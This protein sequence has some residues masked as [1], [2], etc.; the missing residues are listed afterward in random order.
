[1]LDY[2]AYLAAIRRN[3]FEQDPAFSQVIDGTL[4]T[5]WA[6][7][8]RPR[9]QTTGEVAATRWADLAVIANENPPTLRTHNPWGE[10]IDSVEVHPAYDQL[11]REAYEAGVVWPRF[12]AATGGKSSPWGVVFALGYLLGQA[13]QG[14]FCPVCLTAGTAWLLER[15]AE[16]ELKDRYLPRVAAR[17]YDQLFEGAMFLTERAGGSDVG[18]ATVEARQEDGIWKLYGDKWFCSNAGRAQAMMVLARPQGATSGTRGLAL[19]MVP[20]VLED[21]GRNALR[22]NRLKDKL[23]TKS[24]PSG[25]LVFEGATAYAVGPL[26]RGFAA[27]TAMLNLS[28][29]YNT[30]ASV[31]NMRRTINT[32]IAYTHAR[33]AFGR[34][35]D[36]AP[37]VQSKLIEL[38]V[39]AEASLRL[40]FEAI[41]VLDRVEA[42]ESQSREELALRV[43]TPLL[44]YHTAREA[45]DTASACTE[46]LG[47]NGYIEEWQI[48]RFLRDAQVLPIWEGTTNIL[49]L[50]VL[51][52]FAKEGTGPALLAWYGERLSGP[53]PA[54]LAT[55]R[56]MLARE[57]ADL[58]THLL[59][60]S[61]LDDATRQV[62]AKDWCDRAVRAGQGIGLLLAAVQDARDDMGRGALVLSAFLRRHYLVSGWRER[63]AATNPTVGFAAIVRK[64]PVSFADALALLRQEVAI[65]ARP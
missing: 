64:E 33:S 48:A 27:M 55:Y 44:K 23:G 17:S 14:L 63:L 42:G 61:A 20:L 50:D 53:V 30:V 7:W 36:A 11:A 5:E 4:S 15:F 49:V 32:A 28:R 52:S 45:V 2:P 58:E 21:G 65:P 56:D 6:D 16:P 12:A 8:V 40:T 59:A 31:A 29:L 19:F 62:H 3:Y 34:V 39:E 18:A 54:T 35:V 37:M 1:M 51:R 10:R 26:E 13:E 38:E 47:G 22:F 60:L 24:M 9:L 25:E 41:A 46:L 57:V 43:L